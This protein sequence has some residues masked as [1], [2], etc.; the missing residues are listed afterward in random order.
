MEKNVQGADML[1]QSCPKHGTLPANPEIG[2][3]GFAVMFARHLALLDR[4]LQAG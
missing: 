4:L 3:E 2:R 1:R